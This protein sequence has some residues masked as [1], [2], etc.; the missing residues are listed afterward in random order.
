VKLRVKT[1]NKY[2]KR[3]MVSIFQNSKW[4]QQYATEINN[5]FEILENFDNEHS[6]NNNINEKW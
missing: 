4:K 6:I 1:G 3:K 5:R 2:E